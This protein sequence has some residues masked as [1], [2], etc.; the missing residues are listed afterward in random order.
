[1]CL[2]CPGLAWK[3]PNINY[4]RLHY[5]IYA[6]FFRLK[7]T[8]SGVINR[9]YTCTHTVK[10]KAMEQKDTIFHEHLCVVHAHTQTHTH[11][12]MLKTSHSPAAGLSLEDGSS[13]TTSCCNS[14]TLFCRGCFITCCS[15]FS[16]LFAR[17]TTERSFGASTGIPE[18][19][20]Q[21]VVCV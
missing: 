15:P 19:T 20:I 16:E 6:P 8:Y 4:I 17:D 13:L 3:Y 9:M 14:V 1:M 5:I 2:S 12:Y 21:T 11:N 18:L 7:F 10:D